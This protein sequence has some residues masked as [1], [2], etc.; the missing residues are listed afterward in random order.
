MIVF[1]IRYILC[2][3]KKTLHERFDFMNIKKTISILLTCLMLLSL[4]SLTAAADTG[5]LTISSPDNWERVSKD[6]A[7]KIRWSRVLN[8]SGYRIT[9]KNMETGEVYIRNQWTTSRSFSLTRFFEK[10]IPED[11]YPMLKIWVGAME[12][13][14][15][16]AALTS[17]SDDII[18][19]DV[20]EDEEEHSH[21]FEVRFASEHPHLPYCL[22]G[23]IKRNIHPREQIF[24][25]APC[26]CGKISYRRNA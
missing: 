15:D 20:I 3:K 9:L 24:P 26:S 10:Y 6:S 4:L 19:I 12:N 11:E 14:T 25:E 13:K 21:S 23:G 2:K 18:Y 17:I 5:E 22:L 8:A 16:D 1:F 7:P